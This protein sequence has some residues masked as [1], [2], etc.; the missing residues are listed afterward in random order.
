MP[1][2]DETSTSFRF[3]L[4]EPNLF[5]DG[6]F[7]TKEIDTGISLVMGR[8]KEQST[9][10]AQ[11]IVFN[12]EKFKELNQA[13]KWLRD[14]GGAK[15]FHEENGEW[16]VEFSE[17][18]MKTIQ[19]VEI[20]ASGMWN[21]DRFTDDDLNQIVES[22]KKTKDKLRPYVKIGH[23]DSQNLLSKDELPKAGVIENVRKVGSK[24]IADL[25]QVPK[26]VFEVVKRKAF[27]KISSELF[28][29]ID[30]SGE[31]HPFAL[32]AV[33]LLGGETP[34]VHDL[35]SI[36]DLFCYEGIAIGYSDNTNNSKEYD[37]EQSYFNKKEE[38][39]FSMNPEELTRQNARLE[40]KIKSFQ[41]ENAELSDEIKKAEEVQKQYKETQEKLEV[42]N[43][44][45]SEKVNT[46]EKQFRE[47][48]IY[49]AIDNSIKEGKIMP[50][51]RELLFGLITSVKLDDQAK[52]FKVKD[53]EYKSGEE[54]IF[55]LIDSFNE[56]PE[57]NIDEKSGKGKSKDED[58]TIKL[59]EEY[60]E[61]NKVS[62]SQ[63]L[64]EVSK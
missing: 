55:A 42:E 64:I 21:G 36:M 47:S 50:S 18:E 51:Q 34:A 5:Q 46:L 56:K 22:F 4:R 31:R 17:P 33:A 49:T 19:D 59:A 3:R 60:A 27:D 43:K 62:F 10:T 15:A 13:Q 37:F 12:K 23:G 11:S 6:S 45:L 61:K 7:R 32:K 14:H 44:E 26:K 52:V 24:L 16:V 9:M 8:L 57:L 2:W 30:I 63:A 28:V 40:A 20:F 58:A 1:G 29:N 39:G 54:M 25:V 53:K 41:D 48:K 38:E 35:N